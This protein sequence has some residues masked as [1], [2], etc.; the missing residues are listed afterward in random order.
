MENSHVTDCLFAVV[1][2]WRGKRTNKNHKQTTTNHNHTANHGLLH[3][4]SACLIPGG[5]EGLF[6]MYS[7]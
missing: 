5:V 7:P 2:R 4:S 6:A 1:K 3:L